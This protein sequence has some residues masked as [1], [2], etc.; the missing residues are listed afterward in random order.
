[1]QQEQNKILLLLIS[2]TKSNL[3]ETK[4]SDNLYHKD[5]LFTYP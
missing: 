2:H 3:R 4:Y 5:V 1:M